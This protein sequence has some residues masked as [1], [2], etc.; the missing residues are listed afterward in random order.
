MTEK[1]IATSFW[2]AGHVESLGNSVCVNL[3][4][5]TKIIP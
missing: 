3:T 5:M 1:V 4:K 2:N